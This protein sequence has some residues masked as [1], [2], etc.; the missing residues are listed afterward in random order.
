GPTVRD[1]GGP[2]LGLHLAWSGNHV[3]A[4]DR[5]DD[6]LR[7]IH[8]G[9]LFEPGEVRLG[10][11]DAYESP[12][13]HICLAQN[14]SAM[15]AAFHAHGPRS[16]LRWPGGAMRPRPVLLNTWE[17]NY[18]AHDVAALKR[19]AEAAAALGIERFVLDDGWFK[20]RDDD[21]TSLGDWT[22]DAGK[23]PDGLA[24]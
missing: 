21:T 19:Q 20:G 16:V 3:I 22:V 9:E 4:V 1:D 5:T 7:L 2:C 14:L 23:Y 24:P 13:A 11:G 6:G 18:F 10:P 17:G 8:A 12:M 15:S